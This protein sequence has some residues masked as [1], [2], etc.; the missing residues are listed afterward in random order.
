M[1]KRLFNLSTMMAVVCAIVFLCRNGWANPS[2]HFDQTS[3]DFG[4]VVQ[5]KKVTYIFE[6]RNTGDEV[7]TIQNLRAG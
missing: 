6:F 5:G 1:P 3:F 4:E 2:I 7:L